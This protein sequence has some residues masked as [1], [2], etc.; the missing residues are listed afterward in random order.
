MFGLR[1][2]LFGVLSVPVLSLALASGAEALSISALTIVKLGTNT[3]DTLTNN[4]TTF[5]EFKSVVSVLD[6]GGSALDGPGATVDART[7]YSSIQGR[8]ITVGSSNANATTDYQITFTV[9]A[10]I[11][12]LYDLTMASSRVGALTTVDDIIIGGSSGVTLGAVTGRLNTVVNGSLGLAAD[13]VGA[14]ANKAISQSNALVL[15]GLTGTNVITLRFSWTNNVNSSPEE[16]AARFGIAGT[17]P[18]TG[19]MT[20][21][22][23]PGA[24]GRNIN[25]DGHFVLVT[26][27]M[28]TPEPGTLALLGVGLAGLSLAARRRAA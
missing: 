23:Y 26:A 25:N 13:S 9:S 21:D 28:T 1:L 24:G 18:F 2:R 17:A 3:A 15:T 8:D 12:D 10:P 20:A 19:S 4:L 27:L 22:D 16:A 5:N 7:R 14:N 6:S 11:G